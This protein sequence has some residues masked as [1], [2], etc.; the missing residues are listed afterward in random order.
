MPRPRPRVVPVKLPLFDY[1]GWAARLVKSI[2]HGQPVEAAI[3]SVEAYAR[4]VR[5][6]ECAREAARLVGFD[7]DQIRTRSFTATEV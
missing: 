2:R 5:D 7:A 4:E 6:V 3:G 1:E